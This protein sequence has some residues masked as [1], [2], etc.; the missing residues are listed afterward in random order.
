MRYEPLTS[1]EDGG[2]IALILNL[3]W[4]LFILLDMYDCAGFPERLPL[5]SDLALSSISTQNWRDL[6]IRVSAHR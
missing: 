6:S 4:N 5:K 2:S 1:E 3:I